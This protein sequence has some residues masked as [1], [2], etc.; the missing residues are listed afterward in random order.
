MVDVAHLENACMISRIHRTVWSKKGSFIW[1]E[2]QKKEKLFSPHKLG[3]VQHSSVEYH[4]KLEFNFFQKVF[5]R[6]CSNF[7]N[8]VSGFLIK[9]LRVGN[10]EYR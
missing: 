5:T 6:I 10:K 3:K 2:T 4:F 8:Q 1:F 9:T 7:K